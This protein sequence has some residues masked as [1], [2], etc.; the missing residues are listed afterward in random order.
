MEIKIE[1]LNKLVKDADKIFMTP[2]GEK[3]LLDL[4]ELQDRVAE[5]ISS[6]KTTLASTALKLSK[7]FS[8]IQGDKVKVYFRAYGAKYIIDESRAKNLP[9]QFYTETIRKAINTPE[10]DSFVAE[11]GGLPDGIAEPERVKQISFSKKK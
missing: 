9:K 8:S 7:D 1:N 5:A 6:A 10:V 3:V 2:D 11:H 4:L